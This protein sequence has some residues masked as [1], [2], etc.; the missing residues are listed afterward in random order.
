MDRIK[1]EEIVAKEKLRN[2]YEEDSNRLVD[3]QRARAENE[4]Q[5]REFARRE[6][7]LAF[8]R[9]RAKKDAAADEELRYGAE[10]LKAELAGPRAQIEFKY[11]EQIRQINAR[12]SLERRYDS[13]KFYDEQIALVEQLRSKELSEFD[14]LQ[15]EKLTKEQERLVETA[16]IQQDLQKEVARQTIQLQKNINELFNTGQIPVLVITAM[17]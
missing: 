7:D 4:R 14:K 12:R 16:K 3:Q 15:Q 11:S 9:S 2:I 1:S 13:L 10:S 8:E 5:N 6:D 17:G